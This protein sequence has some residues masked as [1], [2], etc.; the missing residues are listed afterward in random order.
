LNKDVFPELVT[1]MGEVE[2]LVEKLSV[3]LYEHPNGTYDGDGS[4]YKS[5]EATN[6]M[7]CPVGDQ[8]A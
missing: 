4:T 3:L 8:V 5:L 6:A 1:R 2:A 7:D